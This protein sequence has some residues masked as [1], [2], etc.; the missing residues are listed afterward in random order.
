MSAAYE[1]FFY[2]LFP[3]YGTIHV[4]TLLDFNIIK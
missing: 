1:S 4:T 2:T 3:L